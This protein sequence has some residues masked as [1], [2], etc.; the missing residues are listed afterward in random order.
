MQQVDMAQL[1]RELAQASQVLNKRAELPGPDGATARMQLAVLAPLTLW[2]A[3]EGNRGTDDN[4]IL[5][6]VV[7]LCASQIVASIKSLETDMGSE[8][9]M[10]NAMLGG[11]AEEIHAIMVGDAGTIIRTPYEPGHA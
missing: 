9:A 7:Q 3:E 5:N 4:T 1:N 2:R 8:V 6:V 10:V 11:I